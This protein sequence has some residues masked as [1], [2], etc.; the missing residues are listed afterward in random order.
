MER[1]SGQKPLGTAI[2]TVGRAENKLEVLLAHLR[3]QESAAVTKYLDAL[4]KAVEL[5]GDLSDFLKS[6]SE[7]TE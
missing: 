7:N 6:Y 5:T 2:A 4:E 3:S 1:D